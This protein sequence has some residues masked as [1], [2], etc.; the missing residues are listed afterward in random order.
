MF[1]KASQVR[2][3]QVKY[4]F[5]IPRVDARSPQ[6]DYAAFLLLYDAPRFG[7]ELLGAAKIVFAHWSNKRASGAA[8]LGSFL[9]EHNVVVRSPPCRVAT[10]FTVH[11]SLVLLH[12]LS[13]LSQ[14]PPMLGEFGINLPDVRIG[15]TKSLLRTFSGAPAAFFGPHIHPHLKQKRRKVGKVPQE[16][17][18]AARVREFK[19]NGEM[20]AAANRSVQLSIITHTGSPGISP[21][22]NPA[23]RLGYGRASADPIS[24]GA[25]IYSD[26]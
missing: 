12:E 7:D 16:L 11:L 21:A 13:L 8:R 15:L 9:Q 17:I 18:A 4:S 6:T 24:A 10:Q 14:R 19:G 26:E 3:E 1:L 22:R 20:H 25:T 5:G 23:S 2:L